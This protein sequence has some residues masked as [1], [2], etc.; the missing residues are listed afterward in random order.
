MFQHDTAEAQRKVI[1]MTDVDPEV[2]EQMLNY[3]Y[4]GNM[5]HPGREAE[6]LAVADKYRWKYNKNQNEW[7]MISFIVKHLLLDRLS[8]EI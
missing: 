2:A 7:K 8:L 6:L 4:T 1:E 5:K 3:I